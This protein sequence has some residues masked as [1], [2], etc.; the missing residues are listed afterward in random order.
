MAWGRARGGAVRFALQAGEAMLCEADLRAD[1]PSRAWVLRRVR[2]TNRRVALCRVPGPLMCWAVV[3]LAAL[4][5]VG[6]P[7]DTVIGLC[8]GLVTMVFLLRNALP[9]R[10]LEREAPAAAL[11]DVTKEGWALLLWFEDGS[12]WRLAPS[13]AVLDLGW[14]TPRG[15]MMRL[16]Q[17]LGRLIGR[18]ADRPGLNT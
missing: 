8:W 16:G 17:A 12:M 14:G 11:R 5:F 9:F 13:Q 1:T 10:V 18:G 7:S 6:S 3:G 4:P 2:V 15:K